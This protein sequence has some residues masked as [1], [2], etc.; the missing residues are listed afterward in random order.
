[1]ARF[2]G[3]ELVNETKKLI[4]EM[5]T[6]RKENEHRLKLRKLNNRQLSSPI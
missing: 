6:F 4:H 3:G 1:M 2:L 5:R